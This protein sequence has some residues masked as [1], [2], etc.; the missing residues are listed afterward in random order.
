MG[1]HNMD[2]EVKTKLDYLE[3]QIEM[4][5]DTVAKMLDGTPV[6]RDDIFKRS[7]KFSHRIAIGCFNCN[8]NV[9]FMGSDREDTEAKIRP[10][11]HYEFLS[12]RMEF[13]CAVCEENIGTT[14]SN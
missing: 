13:F 3:E 4:L 2:F 7:S 5:R 10:H 12:K 14:F 11:M 6:I 1:G 8:K 9:I